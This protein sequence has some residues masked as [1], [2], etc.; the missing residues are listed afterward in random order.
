LGLCPLEELGAAAWQSRVGTPQLIDQPFRLGEE[1]LAGIQ[2]VR[3]EPEG[4][5]DRHTPRAGR[6]RSSSFIDHC[7]STVDLGPSQHRRLANIALARTQDLH[8]VRERP[9]LG[10]TIA[11]NNLEPAGIPAR[12]SSSTACGTTRL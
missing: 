3:D 9:Q 6:L 8:V 10:Q 4:P 5:V 1:Q 11:G 2:A 7:D 12:S